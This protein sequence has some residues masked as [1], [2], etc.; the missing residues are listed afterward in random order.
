YESV[1]H[2]RRELCWI[3]QVVDRCTVDVEAGQGIVVYDELVDLT[4]KWGIPSIINAKRKMPAGTIEKIWT[5]HGTT[6]LPINKEPRKSIS[7]SDRNVLPR[8]KRGLSWMYDLIP[9]LYCRT[10]RNIFTPQ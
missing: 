7:V 1:F 3:G 2:E 4:L 6:Q 10:R 5:R 8:I 9:I